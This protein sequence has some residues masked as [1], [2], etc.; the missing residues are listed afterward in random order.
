[1]NTT[2]H[3]VFVGEADRTG[4]WRQFRNREDRALDAGS[5]GGVKC[6]AASR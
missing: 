6:A 3:T 4:N 1:M 5:D 2:L